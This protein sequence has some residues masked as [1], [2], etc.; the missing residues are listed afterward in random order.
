MIRAV[1]F[2]LGN[3]LVA[4]YP[5]TEFP[6]ILRRCLRRCADVLRLSLNEEQL[7]ERA[8]TLNKDQ[9][10]HAVHPLVDRLQALFASHLIFDEQT[11]EAACDAFLE[12]IFALAMIDPDAIGV[13]DSLRNRGFK[14]AI[15]SNTPW[16]SPAA[17]W[18]RHLAQLGL[19]DRVDA[20]VFCMDV[21]FRK[22]HAAAFRRALDFLA[23]SPAEAIFVGDEPHWDAIG[24]RQAGLRPVLLCPSANEVPDHCVSIQR[25]EDVLEVVNG[26]I[27]GTSVT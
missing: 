3:T 4:Y 26:N 24:A 20:T 14:T 11:L 15:V 1:L 17:P 7:F 9:E 21:G 8:W 13:L 16:G 5:R 19:L 18:R 25:L 23:V 27:T 12:P 6:V 22:P 2:D 10:D